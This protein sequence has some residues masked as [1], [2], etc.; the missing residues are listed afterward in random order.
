M[1]VGSPMVPLECPYG[2]SPSPGTGLLCDH[3]WACPQ[4]RA[5]SPPPQ[6][7]IPP[8]T[9]GGLGSAAAEVFRGHPPHAAPVPALLTPVLAD[10]PAPA[11]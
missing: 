5:P 3:G 9:L 6:P 8:R 4:P 10:C 11:P 2:T 1:G 7:P